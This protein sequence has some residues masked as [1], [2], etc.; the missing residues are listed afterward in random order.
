MALDF[1][2]GG[3]IG[4]CDI[5]G[6]FRGFDGLFFMPWI[7]SV[8]RLCWAIEVL[9]LACWWFIKLVFWGLGWGIWVSLLGDAWNSGELVDFLDLVEFWLVY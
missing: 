2:V 4:W 8:K 5:C 9:K 3:F 1:V 6:C 7:L